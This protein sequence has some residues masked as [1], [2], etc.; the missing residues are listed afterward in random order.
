[1]VQVEDDDVEGCGL[2]KLRIVFIFI[3]TEGSGYIRAFGT[4]N[5]TFGEANEINQTFFPLLNGKA[6]L[7]LID[8]ES[9]I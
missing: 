1:V 7:F 5:W 3:L 8:H 2:R 6:N 9:K 4:F